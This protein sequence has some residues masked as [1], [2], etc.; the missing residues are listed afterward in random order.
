[1]KKRV[2][3]LCLA[4][5]M[6][7][8][9]MPGL[10][11]ITAA[12]DSERVWGIDAATIY[13]GYFNEH[14]ET[15]KVENTYAA[16]YGI[17]T[18][19]T[20]CY[21]TSDLI[22]KSA[23]T[24]QKE[25]VSF[26][27]KRSVAAMSEVGTFEFTQADAPGGTAPAAMNSGVY[28]IDVDFANY[29]GA[30]GNQAQY[31]LTGK[32]GEATVDLAAVNF[33]YDSKTVSLAAADGTKTGTAFTMTMNAKTASP[34]YL[35]L[36]VDMDN[37]TVS[38]YVAAYADAASIGTAPELS[39]CTSLGTVSFDSAVSQLTAMDVQAI[40]KAEDWSCNIHSIYSLQVSK[41]KAGEPVDPPTTYAVTVNAGEGGTA[42]MTDPASGTAFEEGTRITI[43][44]TANSGYTFAGWR[45]E[46]IDLTSTAEEVIFTMPANAVT[47][48]ANFTESA[49]ESDL[50]VTFDPQDILTVYRT[51]NPGTDETGKEIS[52]TQPTWLP[53][54]AGITVYPTEIYGYTQNILNAA[55]THRKLSFYTAY[56]SNKG[57]TK[58]IEFDVTPKS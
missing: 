28:E 21:N 56:R 27:V 4:L 44:A 13:A 35:R 54:N 49:T 32:A 11:G 12:A 48:T 10:G 8:M 23:S 26:N 30:A 51:V 3:S 58:G 1:M 41:V 14:I 47:I 31:V 18:S 45:A 25:A 34:G 19:N 9:A 2:V 55:N 5:S 29:F 37:H 50:S 16:Q 22:E 20:Y 39:D 7:L 17:T 42:A 53:A 57:Y 15:D 43:K 36:N 24:L 33:D 38:A 40:N 6:L 52:G 46:G